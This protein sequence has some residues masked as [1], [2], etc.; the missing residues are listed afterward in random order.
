M[1]AA[2]KISQLG[3]GFDVAWHSPSGGAPS[4]WPAWRQRAR[5]TIFFCTTR[6][7][8]LHV[9]A[10]RAHLGWEASLPLRWAGAT[11]ASLLPPCEQ[12]AACTGAPCV[13]RPRT[14]SCPS[15]R[16]SSSW[17]PRQLRRPTPSRCSLRGELYDGLAL[18]S[19]LRGSYSKSYSEIMSPR[20]R[21]CVP[22]G[23]ACRLRRARALSHEHASSY[24]LA[25][26]SDFDRLAGAAAATASASMAQGASSWPRADRLTVARKV[27]DF[28]DH[29]DLGTPSPVSVPDIF[30]ALPRSSTNLRA[31]A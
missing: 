3:Q 6:A 13:Q 29:V 21:R 10:R 24:F 26:S 17:T 2:P 19:P 15:C 12:V 30:A 31:C 22:T 7:R 4:G 5:L 28:D 14:P 20:H 11:R 23:L 8:L 18:H 16:R 27:K 1:C 9:A 25:G